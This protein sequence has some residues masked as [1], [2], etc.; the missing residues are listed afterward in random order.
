MFRH[1]KK[2]PKVLIMPEVIVAKSTKKCSLIE[3]AWAVS[4][5][6]ILRNQDGQT[7]GRREGASGS[8]WHDPVL[9]TPIIGILWLTV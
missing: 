6:T 8:S 9:M 1:M 3:L 2:A 5:L 4:P 7:L